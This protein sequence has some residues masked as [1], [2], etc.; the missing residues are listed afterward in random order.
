[1]FYSIPLK[2]DPGEG[3][4]RGKTAGWGQTLRLSAQAQASKSLEK[5]H[6]RGMSPAL[7]N[8]YSGRN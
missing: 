2:P 1:M 4:P 5:E 6:K 7:E 3:A 8:Q